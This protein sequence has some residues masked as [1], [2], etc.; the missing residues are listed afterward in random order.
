[1]TAQMKRN[2]ERIG[3]GA[4][5]RVENNWTWKKADYG[6]D[7]VVG[8]RKVKVKPREP[9]VYAKNQG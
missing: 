5:T 6:P 8:D 1:M 2:W 4:R 7:G 3:E 9:P